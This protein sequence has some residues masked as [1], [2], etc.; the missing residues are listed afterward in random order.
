MDA[1]YPGMGH[2]CP[3]DVDTRL[4]SLPLATVLPVTDTG[5]LFS[6]FEPFVQG[7][8]HLSPRGSIM[9]CHRLNDWRE[10]WLHSL[11]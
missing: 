8:K 11:S 6:W 2:E 1:V 9:L 5:F 10:H 3:S 4:T 7:L